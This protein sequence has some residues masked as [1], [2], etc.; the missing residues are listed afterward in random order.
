[1]SSVA[2]QPFEKGDSTM[3]WLKA[4]ISALVENVSGGMKWL[5]VAGFLIGLVFAAIY[6]GSLDRPFQLSA[7]E[8]FFVVTTVASLGLNLY[9]YV[10]TQ[11]VNRPLLNHLV[12]VFNDIK[13]K[14]QACWV[15]ERNSLACPESS[16]GRRDSPVGVRG[17]AMMLTGS[18]QQ[19]QE[20]VVA[21]IVTLDPSDPVGNRAFRAQEYGLTGEERDMREI[22]RRR[23]PVIRRALQPQRPVTK[24]DP[25]S[26][27]LSRR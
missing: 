26:L 13:S 14:Q 7:L 22:Q 21:A 2:A 15:V 27:H 17:F 11:S 12:G 18:F 9:Q 8:L 1:M 5:A 20:A 3:P 6:A 19:L 24:L 16:Q 23:F 10:K 25:V 4:T